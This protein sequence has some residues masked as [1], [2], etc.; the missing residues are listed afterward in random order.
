[1]IR[2]D[3]TIYSVLQSAQMSAKGV[4]LM[5]RL[6]HN[7]TLMKNNKL[8]P[9]ANQPYINMETYRKTGV[10]VLTPVWFAEENGVLYCYTPSIAAK[11]KRIRN[12]P[13]VRI[14]PSDA[15]GN[16]KGAWVE[17]QARI[18]GEA[19]KERGL[20]LLNQKYGW[21]KKLIDFFSKL[22][23]RTPVVIAIEV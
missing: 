21:Q 16:P 23:G 15:R 3:G 20:Q 5:K 1:M 7:S 11:V 17:A 10:P 6:V 8:A 19:E 4:G 18:V 14:V 22:R 2:R 12:N 13:N 9:F